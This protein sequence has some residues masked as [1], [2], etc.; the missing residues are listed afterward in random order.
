ML[1]KAKEVT[2]DK[3]R[4]PPVIHEWLKGHRDLKNMPYVTHY[5]LDFSNDWLT[6]YEG[7]QPTQWSTLQEN[8]KLVLESDPWGKLRNGNP[9]SFFFV[10][11]DNRQHCGAIF[12]FGC[13]GIWCVKGDV[14]LI[15]G[16]G[17]AVGDSVDV[18]W[19]VGIVVSI[20]EGGGL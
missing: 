2:L 4:W 12:D 6:W 1:K 19:L 9:N 14:Q 5:V 10:A 20:G 13:S 7:L 8:K 16:Y 17:E 11:T 3:T 15:F 18:F